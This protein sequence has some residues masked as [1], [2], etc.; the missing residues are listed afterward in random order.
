MSAPERSE[1]FLPRLGCYVRWYGDYHVEDNTCHLR[2]EDGPAQ[3]T[4]IVHKR[5]N[6][7]YLPQG[8]RCRYV[9]DG[10]PTEYDD[11]DIAACA[12]L[13]L[14]RVI[15][16]AGSRFARIVTVQQGA[17]LTDCR[18]D[19]RSMSF[20][21]KGNH[22]YILGEAYLCASYRVLKTTLFPEKQP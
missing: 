16:H 7:A 14:C 2:L 17:I 18:Y 9:V 5:S 11:F 21:F 10:E 22:Y 20:L 8:G 13:G 4:G 1:V 15:Q 3:R 6:A 12:A 19:P